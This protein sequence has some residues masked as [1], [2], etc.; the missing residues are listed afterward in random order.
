MCTQKMIENRDDE[1]VNKDEMEEI[2][3][4]QDDEEVNKDEMEEIRNHQDNYF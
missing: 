2:R 4:H 3:N 1:E